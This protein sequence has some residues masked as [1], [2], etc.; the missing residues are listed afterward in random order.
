MKRSAITEQEHQRVAQAI[1]EAE[2]ST[3]GEIYCVVAQRSDGYFFSSALVVILSIL[4]ISLGVAFLIEA[5]WLTMRLPVFV[6]AQLLAIALALLLIYALP[7]LRVRLAPR[8][9]QYIRAHDNALKQFLGRNVHMTAE[10]TGVLIFVSLAERYAEIIADAGIAT[11]VPQEMWDSIV[12]GLIEDA[13][14]DRLTDGFVTSIA[15]V[16]ALLSEHFP[17]RVDD[18]N[19]LDDHLVEL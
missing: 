10:C 8:R 16:G 15:A 18:I 2:A 5:W 6:G 14:N 17:V 7:D 4:I 13:G 12:A 3:S 9:W 19:E 1:R 11:Q